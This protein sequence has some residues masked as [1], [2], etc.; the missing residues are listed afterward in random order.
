MDNLNETTTAIVTKSLFS[1]AAPRN[2]NL[3][4]N[5]TSLGSSMMV[6]KKGPKNS[7]TVI[8]VDAEVL[9]KIKAK[10]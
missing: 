6:H 5:N 9:R 8:K 10:K 1:P 3:S 4:F 2:P 7:A